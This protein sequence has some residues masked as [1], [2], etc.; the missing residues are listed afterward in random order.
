MSKGILMMILGA[1]LLAD[2][3]DADPASQPEKH[4]PEWTGS[5]ISEPGES[6]RGINRA[7]KDATLRVAETPETT[8][9]V[10]PELAGI[11]VLCAHDEKEKFEK[12]WSRYVQEH[13][14]KGAELQKTIRKVSDEAVA[15]RA[16]ERLLVEEKEQQ[17]EEAWKAEKRRQ[18][19]EAA[20][21][22]LN[23]I[24]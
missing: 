2:I 20:R 21:K 19:Q 6:D 1:F 15:Y 23:P 18:M 22:V 17:E 5:N 11:V 4:Q 9:P 16:R 13:E 24:W 3:A 8:E 12:E 10:T 7:M 14:L